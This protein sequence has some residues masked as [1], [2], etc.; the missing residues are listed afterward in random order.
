[1]TFD[2]V[3]A[4]TVR[5]A[6]NLEPRFVFDEHEAAAEAKLAAYRA[7]GQAPERAG[8]PL[9]RRGLGR[10]RLL[11][12]RGGGGRGDAEHRQ[13][14]PQ[15]QAAHV[16]LQRADLHAVARVARHR[17]PPDAPRA[18]AP[19]DVRPARR[20]RTAS[21][22]SPSCC[23][24]TATSPRPSASGT[25]ARTSSR[26]PSTW[27]STTSTASSRCPTCTRSGAI[28]YFFPE[29]VYSDE[30]TEW[31]KNMQFNKCFVHATRGGDT[32]DVEEVTIPVLSLLDEKWA[33]Y[34]LDFLRRM[35][36]TA[37]RRRGAVVPLPLHPRRALRQL[38]APRL[39]RPLAGQAPLQGHDH[40][41][42]RHRRAAGG[43]ARGD[44]SAR[45]HAH[46]PLVRQRA[47]DGELAR[48]GV[49]ARSA[50]R[51][52]RRGRAASGCPA[53][54]ELAGHDRAR[55][56]HRRAVLPDGPLQHAAA[57][58]RRRAT[59]SRTTATS[60]ASTRRRSSSATTRR[61]TASS[62][63]TG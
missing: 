5:E 13:A 6:P 58:G 51:R 59:P 43:R 57:P 38:P 48:L 20:A 52:A 4:D 54:V 46:L 21:A 28:P 49:H 26:S 10:L 32:E 11:R 23:P 2:P 31:V 56:G 18:A 15:R 12:R 33:D 35:G 60:T 63:S 30:R 24:R 27:A 53:I 7:G 34:S 39:P 50:A 55:P 8:H 37:R 40:R 16:V 3:V 62:S 44:R 25:W 36:A 42:R 47:R 17:A 61:R 1:M 22:P 29:I 14:G 41:A 45:R 19:A 9:R